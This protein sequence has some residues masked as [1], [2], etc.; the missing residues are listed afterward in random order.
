M[1]TIQLLKC[2]ESLRN[3]CSDYALAKL[4]SILHRALN[5]IQLI[6]PI[7]LLLSF[8][9]GLIKLM[10]N[11][12]DKKGNKPLFNKIIAAV[13]CFIMPT[14]INLFFNIMPET[15]EV[16]ACWKSAEEIDAKLTPT[17]NQTSQSTTGPT[18]YYN[19]TTSS[20]SSSS[21]SIK[22]SARGQ[23][24]A[25]YAKQFVGKKYTYGGTWNG[26]L[27]YTPTD[28]SGFVQ[29]VYRHFG[30]NLKRTTS[31]QWNDKSTYTLVSA[32]DIR[33]GDIVMYRDHVAIATGNGNEIVHASNSRDGV[34]LTANYN[35]NSSN[36]LG[37]MRVNGVN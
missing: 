18:K 32:N 9:I 1:N 21:S 3:C 6:A 5:L 26:E 37:I 11:P 31:A 30:I 27:P 12:D 7:L 13:M 33:A 25:A 2:S 22:G 16:G 14:I 35:Y 36:L 4:L 17:T 8:V 29:G 23:E 24:I 15:V 19:S 34:K 28:C 20:S 10:I